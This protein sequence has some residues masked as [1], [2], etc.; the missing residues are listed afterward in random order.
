MV[1]KSNF[2]IG[3][4]A[5]TVLVSLTAGIVSAATV[6]QNIT[7]QGKLTDAAGNP[8]TGTYSV[9]FKLYDVSSGGTALATDIHSV[10]A[11]KGLFTTQITADPGIFDGRAVWLGVK[12]GSDAEMTPRQEIRP[13][14][15]ALGLRPGAV[16]TG[17]AGANPS[18]K[19]IN[20][21]NNVAALLAGTTGT[22]SPALF[23]N[24]LGASPAVYASSPNDIGVYGIGKTGAFFTT[25]LAGS[26]GNVYPGVNVSTVYSYN[27]GVLI[28]TIGN[29]SNGVTAQTWGANSGGVYAVTNG[30]HSAGVMAITSGNSSDGVY[31]WTNRDDSE[32]VYAQTYGDHSDGISARTYGTNSAGVYAYSE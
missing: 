13:V 28:N 20:T 31:A 26:A 32:G 14:P 1:K 10:T 21:G 30:D 12:V 16:I 11:S 23:A 5:V 17:D 9:T 3:I 8:L 15:Y 4:C 24:A 6:T 27:D 19:V 2:L 7:Y 25:N 29:W 22:N 18:L